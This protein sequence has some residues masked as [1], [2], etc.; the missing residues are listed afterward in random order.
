MTSSPTPNA[1]EVGKSL[2]VSVKTVNGHLALHCDVVYVSNHHFRVRCRAP[3]PGRTLFPGQEARIRPAENDTAIAMPCKYLRG[4]EETASEIVL[5]IPAGEWRSNRRAFVRV[6]LELPVTLTRG[7]DEPVAG[8]TLDLSGGGA[9]VQ[10]DRRAF[11]V[12]ETVRFEMRMPAE[13]DGALVQ[14]D[15]RVVRD[16]PRGQAMYGLLFLKARTR[17]HNLVCKAV[18]VKQFEDRRAE[19]REVSERSENR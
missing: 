6:A 13:Q 18:I 14:F 12:G 1:I 8:K 7:E 11:A 19:L 16:D 5:S 3:L 4:N 10:L 2:I 9:L 17:D 15:A